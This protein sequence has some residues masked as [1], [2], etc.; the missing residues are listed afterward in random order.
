MLLFYILHN[1]NLNKTTHSLRVYNHTKFQHY[2]HADILSK[3]LKKTKIDGVINS[4]MMFI[5]S[6]NKTYQ[7][8]KKLLGTDKHI[9]MM[10]TIPNYVFFLSSPHDTPP[11]LQYELQINVKF[12]RR[13]CEVDIFKVSNTFVRNTMLGFF[14]KIHI[15]NHIFISHYDFSNHKQI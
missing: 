14:H 3:T 10:V 13:N 9:D 12:Q 7:L 4:G 11:S 1:C 2:H 6:L 15:K 8:T 5:P